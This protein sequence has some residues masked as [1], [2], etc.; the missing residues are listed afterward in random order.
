MLTGGS[1]K[2]HLFSEENYHQ[3]FHSSCSTRYELSIMYF[4]T[5]KE[6]AP[7]KKSKQMK[8]KHQNE[9]QEPLKDH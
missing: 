2:T 7:Y 5:F 1:Y 4:H 8:D 6:T 3:C 9:G